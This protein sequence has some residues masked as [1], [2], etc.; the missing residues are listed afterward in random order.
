M[1]DALR[2]HK[3]GDIVEIVIRRGAQLTTVRATLG[4]RGG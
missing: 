1:T 4:T 2:S 3:P